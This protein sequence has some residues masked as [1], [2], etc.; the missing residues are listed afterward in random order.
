MAR[1]HTR[2]HKYKQ[3]LEDKLVSAELS[4]P[5][6]AQQENFWAWVSIPV[7]ESVAPEL[8]GGREQAPIQTLQPLNFPF[9]AR[10]FC[11]RKGIIKPPDA[12]FARKTGVFRLWRKNGGSRRCNMPLPSLVACQLRCTPLSTNRHSEQKRPRGASLLSWGATHCSILKQQNA[13]AALSSVSQSS[14][15][16]AGWQNTCR[17]T[18]HPLH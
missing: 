15:H 11:P 3:V 18:W 1:E 8:L 6:W 14:A 9:I 16:C 17:H 4:L 13:S 10:W 5:Y 12:T 7:S 2:L